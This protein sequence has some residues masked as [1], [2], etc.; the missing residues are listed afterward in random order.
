[1]NLV[2]CFLNCEIEHFNIYIYSR[3]TEEDITHISETKED[4][5]YIRLVEIWSSIRIKPI[6][7]FLSRRLR[8]DDSGN[9][10]LNSIDEDEERD[11][12][13]ESDDDGEGDEVANL[14]HYFTT[15]LNRG[16]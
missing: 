9:N 4:A 3:I 15:N 5:A 1:M 14:S 16:K 12:D 7:Y 11:E 8:K 2:T 13:E 10:T 6:N